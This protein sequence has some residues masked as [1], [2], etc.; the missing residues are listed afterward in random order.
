[1]PRDLGLTTHYECD[2]S[3]LSDQIKQVCAWCDNGGIQGGWNMVADSG[4]LA[5]RG[6]GSHTVT[7]ICDRLEDLVQFKMV[8]LHN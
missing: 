3:H 6:N 8:W 2:I 5:A 1:M 4:V 7:F